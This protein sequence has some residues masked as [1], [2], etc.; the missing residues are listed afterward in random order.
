MLL[1][2]TGRPHMHQSTQGQNNLH[3]LYQMHDMGA[4]GHR[5]VPP[6][7]LL[8]E[9]SN[10]FITESIRIRL[11]GSESKC[12]RR[13]SRK[14]ESIFV[15][16]MKNTHALVSMFSDPSPLLKCPALVSS[17]TT[18]SCLWSTRVEA[19]VIICSCNPSTSRFDVL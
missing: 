17:A 1:T 4:Q 11:M 13:D 5:Q 8:C 12:E 16:T 2:H 19:D 10:G 6:S 3:T 14:R 9:I 7:N 15:Q 18:V